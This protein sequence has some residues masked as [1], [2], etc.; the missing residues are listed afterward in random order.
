LLV[1]VALAIRHLKND[2]RHAFSRSPHVFDLRERKY[3]GRDLRELA[4]LMRRFADDFQSLPTPEKSQ[5]VNCASN[6]GLNCPQVRFQ[7]WAPHVF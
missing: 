2:A 7:R 3:F 1:A 4:R 5:F 6:S